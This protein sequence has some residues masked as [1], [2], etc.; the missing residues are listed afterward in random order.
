M[1]PLMR[2]GATQVGDEI[3]IYGGGLVAD[4]WNYDQQ[5]NTV[6]FFTPKTLAIR[7]DVID[8]QKKPNLKEFLLFAGTIYA[9][10]TAIII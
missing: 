6:H 2:C 9:P 7:K 4:E 1:P 5:L 3:A 10:Y 8:L